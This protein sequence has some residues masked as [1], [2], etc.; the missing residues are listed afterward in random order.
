MSRAPETPRIVHAVIGETQ[1]LDPR[2]EILAPE[3]G[4]AELVG[5]EIMANIVALE[6][7]MAARKQLARHPVI[8]RAARDHDHIEAFHRERIDEVACREELAA[9][10]KDSD[11]R[12]PRELDRQRSASLALTD[13]ALVAP[14]KHRTIIASEDPR[15]KGKPE[16]LIP[17]EGQDG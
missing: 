1:D 2:E 17:G 10:R 6:E 15:I 5:A 3:P 12:R 9:L 16:A 7:D 11:N 13:D 8:E 4:E 14:R